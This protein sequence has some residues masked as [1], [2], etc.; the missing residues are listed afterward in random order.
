MNNKTYTT[1]CY[2]G[3][4]EVYGKYGVFYDNGRVMTFDTI[5]EFRAFVKSL[6]RKG[7]I[8]GYSAIK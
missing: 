7:Y 3:G 1:R 8:R 6:E 4:L 5:F 2:E